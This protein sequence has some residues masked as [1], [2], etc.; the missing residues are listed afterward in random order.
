MNGL[1]QLLVYGSV[2]GGQLHSLDVLLSGVFSV[3]TRI[4]F[5]PSVLH[6]GSACMVCPR[7]HMGT[8]DSSL[9]MILCVCDDVALT[10][11]GSMSCSQ[12]L[13]KGIAWDGRDVRSIWNEGWPLIGI[14]IW[15]WEG[16]G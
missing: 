14:K 12:V 4:C 15:V 8:S 2:D 6:E 3:Q 11:T 7:P 13:N 9:S 5:T 16:G 1:Q 10:G